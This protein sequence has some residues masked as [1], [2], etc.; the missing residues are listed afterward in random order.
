VAI[1]NSDAHGT[2]FRLGPIP[3]AVL[4]YEYLFRCVN[5]HLLIEKPLTRNVNTDRRMIY[6]ALR[7]GHAFVGYDLGAP[8]QGFSFSARSGM[9]NVTMGDELKR[10]GA[11]QFEVLS[12]RHA[13]INLLRNGRV[14]ASHFGTRLTYTNIDPGVYRVEV[15]RTFCFATRGWIYSNPIYVR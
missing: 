7:A 4:P 10:R 3:R 12:P 15:H 13:M 5:T 8:T 9:D 1:G 2:P 11:T 14:I 6:D